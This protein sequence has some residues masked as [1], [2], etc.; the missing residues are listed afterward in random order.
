MPKYARLVLVSDAKCE[1]S[2]YVLPHL[3][4]SI[5]QRMEFCMS[6]RLTKPTHSAVSENHARHARRLLALLDSSY[7]SER[8]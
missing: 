2:Q 7:A 1:G 6:R 3:H 4:A 5:R 8:D